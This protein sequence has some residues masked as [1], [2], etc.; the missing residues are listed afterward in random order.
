MQLSPHFALEELTLSEYAA[1]HDLDNN[2]S[3]AALDNLRKAAAGMETVRSALNAQPIHVTSGYR[4]PLVNAGVGGAP[5]S[6]HC[7]G[8]AVDFICP[9]FGSNYLVAQTIAKASIP[10][11]QLILEYGWVHVSFAPA[12]RCDCLTKKSA[13]APYEHGLIP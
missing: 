3:P 9:G 6:A 8:Y 10:F 4:S 5:S 1:R 13:S 7:N 12:L 11:D 2:P